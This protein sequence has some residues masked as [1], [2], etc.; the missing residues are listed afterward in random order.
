[1]MGLGVGGILNT[2]FEGVNLNDDGLERK[3]LL[4]TPLGTIET[5]S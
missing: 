1:M 3:K 4:A 2:E 5:Q